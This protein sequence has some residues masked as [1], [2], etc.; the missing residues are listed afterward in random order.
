MSDIVKSETEYSLTVTARLID[1][2]EHDYNVTAAC[3]FAGCTRESYY[4]WL[5]AHPDFAEKMEAAQN[6]VTVKAAEVASQAIKDGDVNTARWYLD[7]R[8]PRF[9][10]KAEMDNNIGLQETRKKLGDV[11]DERSADDFSEQPSAT[12]GESRGNEIPE[13]TP[14]IS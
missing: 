1:A 13:N 11:L 10:P 4:N 9:K 14:D 12:S 2:F 3:R 6:H 7:R 8:D 5:K